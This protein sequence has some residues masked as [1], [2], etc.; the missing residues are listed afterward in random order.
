MAGLLLTAVTGTGFAFFVLLAVLLLSV[1]CAVLY[2]KDNRT[3]VLTGLLCFA[4]GAFS[5][6]I[7]YTLNVMPVLALENQT[8]HIIATVAEDP[9]LENS[10]YYYTLETTAVIASD[11]NLQCP[12]KLRL[13][14]SATDNKGGGII[15]AEKYDTVRLNVQLSP[16]NRSPYTL[17]NISQGYYVNADIAQGEI[18][19][20]PP[21]TKPWYSC[22]DD[23]RN[24]LSQNIQKCVKGESG[25][26]LTVLLLGDKT[27]LNNSTEKQ[28]REAG[29]SHIIVVSGLHLSIIVSSVFL[30][31]N[32]IFKK[33]K[34]SAVVATFVIVFYMCITGFSYSVMRSAIMNMIYML[35]FFIYKKPQAV[36]S[37]GFAGFI[38]TML[39][40]L[41]IGN[42]SLLMSFSA[43]LGITTLGSIL[44]DSFNK[45]LPHSITHG[46][47][48]PLGIIVKYITE[49]IF[50]SLSATVFTLPVMVFV[51]Q[52]FSLYFILSNLLVTAIAPITIMC[53]CALVIL[54][55]IPFVN[56]LAHIPSVV[57]D[58]LCGFMLWVSS[59]VSQMPYAVISLEGIF[60]KIAMVAVLV[61]ITVFFIAQGFKIKN[62]YSCVAVSISTAVMILSVG[63]LVMSNSLCIQVLNTGT[64][65][66]I[67][68]KNASGLNILSS[69]GSNYYSSS[70]INTL[71][72]Y[73]INSLL[74]PNSNSYYSKYAIDILETF[75]VKKVLLGNDNNYSS[76][77]IE[78]LR[79]TCYTQFT[80][81]TTIQYT[82]YSVTVF[83]CDNKQWMYITSGNGSILLA[84]KKGD[85][86]LL[87][88][89]Y[90]HC[91]VFIAQ[92]GCVNIDYIT[93]ENIVFCGADNGNGYIC[94]ANGDV[95]IYKF[96]DGR[97]YLWQS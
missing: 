51:F 22:F 94:T 2:K 52:Q 47:G 46:K 42:I 74:I 60:V 64:G 54:P 65:A 6:I 72:N 37:L 43:T 62:V 96:P 63:V 55:Y 57:A 61:V 23:I 84:P 24:F 81:D 15:G 29:I 79:D 75:D 44:C 40:P 68:E 58:C 76:E 18:T 1:I 87:P 25:K 49:C 38:I 39:N 19:V 56:I 73:K 71:E 77:L 12:Q 16:K 53:G 20:T 45:K 85:C 59:V 41:A 95:T 80:S 82:G 32:I 27:Q 33:R 66:T 30:F 4:A 31:I 83:S 91:N 8:V 26:L 69:G 10:R 97:F 86:S 13:R 34:V 70:T 14:L 50:I 5:Y 35:S 67:T 3:A 17:H 36:N 93:T 90:T 11:K 78:V 89:K 92:S 9:S 7:A 88:Q 48:K 28:F 21:D